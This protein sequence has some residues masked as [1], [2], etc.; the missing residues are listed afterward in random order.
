MISKEK[1]KRMKKVSCSALRSWTGR[2]LSSSHDL[3]HLLDEL[4]VFLIVVMTRVRT[5][6]TIPVALRQLRIQDVQAVEHAAAILVPRNVPQRAAVVLL[7]LADGLEVM[8]GALIALLLGV[9]PFLGPASAGVNISGP[10]GLGA[11]RVGSQN[12]IAFGVGVL[13]V[14]GSSPIPT[15]GRGDRHSRRRH[16]RR[17]L[18]SD[19][20]RDPLCHEGDGDRVV[21]WNRADLLEVVDAGAQDLAG[22]ASRDHL[23]EFLVLHHVADV[24]EMVSNLIRR[25]TRKDGVAVHVLE[26]PKHRFVPGEGRLPV[27]L[28]LAREQVRDNR[29][30]DGHRRGLMQLARPFFVRLHASREPMFSAPDIGGHGERA[31]EQEISHFIEAGNGR[32]GLVQVLV[33]RFGALKAD[34][35]QNQASGDNDDIVAGKHLAGALFVCERKM[36]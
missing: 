21:S 24:A 6:G 12:A 33:F 20:S 15:I 1:Q 34:L 4:L 26:Q 35:L 5:V 18:R 16:L 31:L 36:T 23:L 27:L 28:V 30:S 7:E 9:A 25:G 32:Q 13:A 3:P 17:H 22:V 19:V 14:S 11:V 2:G 8:R 29:A 10:S